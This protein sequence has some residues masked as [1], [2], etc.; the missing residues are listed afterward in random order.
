MKLS[1]LLQACVA[2]GFA[3]AESQVPI[4]EPTSNSG[5]FALYQSQV[6]PNHSIRVKRQN[7]TLCN[8]PVDQYTGWLDVGHKHLFFW[9]FKSES[10]S[11][12]TD[13]EPLGLWLTGGPGGSSMLGMLQE[14][15]PCLINEHGNG[16]TYNPYGWNKETAFI[17]VDQ[18][19]GV[20]FSYVDEGESIPGDSFTSAADMHLFLQMFVSQVFPEHKNGPVVITGESYAGHY[21]PALGAQ[22]VAQNI[23]HPKQPQV[24][25]KSVAIGNGYVSP[26]DTAYGYWETLC[27][28]NPGVKKPIFNETRCDIMATNLPRCMAVSK[29]CYDHPDPAICAAAAEVC[30]DG[31][32]K[33]YDGESGAGGRNRFD[34]TL[35]CEI[36]DVCYPNTLWIQDYLNL[37]S[38]FA[39]LGVPKE[40]KKFSVI[41][42]AVSDA[43][44]LTDDLSISLVP[45]VQYLLANQIDLL[46]YQGNLDLACNTA[47]A[48][49]WT[50]N[51]PWKGQSEFNS[52]DL[53]P[54]KSIKNGK[55]A[56]VGA[57]KEVNIKMVEGDE[58]K[59]RFALVTIDGSGHMVPQDQP[60]VALDMLSRW[61]NGKSFA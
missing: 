53:K 26:L 59:T 61:L 18:P 23:L 13:D 31:V 4:I 30:W 35:P 32:V 49:R 43:F 2:S 29:T 36:D 7:S 6:S 9:Y 55:E 38:S 12:K 34:I 44:E 21:L 41:S 56:V 40:I 33:W 46:I 1:L 47:G 8:T 20:G 24:H 52:I 51:M 5:D 15:G 50:A 17:F 25:L 10:A 54:W 11:S 39:A 57:W 60:E 48:K 45:E 22:I 37:P 42:P 3:L 19:A 58:K 14:L 28:T 16:T 27:T